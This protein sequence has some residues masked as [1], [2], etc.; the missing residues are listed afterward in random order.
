[1]STLYSDVVTNTQVIVSCLNS[2]ICIHC[3]EWTIVLPLLKLEI[4]L[5]K[6]ISSFLL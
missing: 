6:Y 2:T 4:A 3:S 5:P 1:V